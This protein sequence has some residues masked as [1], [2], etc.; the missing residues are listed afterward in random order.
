MR[1]LTA[2]LLS[3]VFAT[4]CAAENAVTNGSFEEGTSGWYRNH[5]YPAGRAQVVERPDRGHC[6]R[7]SSQGETVDYAQQLELE[8]GRE[9]VFQLDM[10]RS[11]AGKEIAAYVVISRPN[12]R[13]AYY[14]L[15]SD[16]LTLNRWQHFARRVNVP[17]N[18][19]RC[20][21]L[22][23]NRL[24]GATAWFDDVQVVPVQ[25]QS[26]PADGW[27]PKLSL[28]EIDSPE[29]DGRLSDG[30]W[31]DAAHVT[32]FAII[33]DGSQPA[34][35]TQAWVARTQT[36]L[37]IAARCN[38]PRMDEIEATT[39]EHDGGG[40]FRD[41]VVEIFID[42]DNDHE[43]YY[44]LAVN[45]IGATY[46]RS[47]GEGPVNGAQFESS[48]QAAVTQ[49]DDHWSVEVAIPLS[50]LA[51]ADSGEI[52]G[53]NIA[54]ER[55]LPEARENSA[56]SAT[57]S[58]FHAPWRFGDLVGLP[59]VMRTVTARFEGVDDPTPGPGTLRFVVENNAN[60]DRA[61]LLRATVATPSG[62]VRT[63]EREAVAPAHTPREVALPVTINARG[64][65]Q[66][67][68][69][70]LDARTQQLLYSAPPRSFVVPPVLTA[71]LAVPAYRGRIFS[72]MNL[73]AI[74]VEAQIGLR[75]PEAQ[76]LQLLARLRGESDVMRTT[77]ADVKAP[78]AAVR[79]PCA[80]LPEGRYFIDV[81]LVA[82]DNTVL[83]TVRDLPVEKLPPAD[84][85]IHGLPPPGRGGR[86]R[87]IYLVPHLRIAAP[88]EART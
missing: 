9:H 77:C 47:L 55:H 74:E 48:M 62:D 26:G 69:A 14:S 17:A 38:E 72:S 54:R 19:S 8:T 21:L 1:L 45:C 15:G 68:A 34:A 79:I 51:V 4:T 44:H 3:A 41:E 66:V 31:D 75:Q 18:A 39:T 52:W 43:T 78:L 86:G 63:A 13:D 42:A 27:C 16:S 25:S 30:E 35:D 36:D 61:I 76:D 65:W 33:T 59:G 88:G 11:G 56:W 28:P 71:D 46:D 73:Q 12:A 50:A 29:I 49:A 2:A 81:Q 6:L 5:D 7:L 60:E 84:T 70:I 64:T 23:M 24:E 10:K 53:L 87:R 57:G 83:G 82:G 67:A 32:G 37:L 22:V 58:R 20:L 80:D 85:E 40:I